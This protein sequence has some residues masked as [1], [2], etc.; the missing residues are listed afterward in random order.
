MI[1]L[2]T[3]IFHYEFYF[4]TQKVIIIFDQQNQSSLKL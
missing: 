4:K 3:T 1:L 2:V